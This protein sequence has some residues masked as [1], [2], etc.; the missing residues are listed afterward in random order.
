MAFFILT[1]TTVAVLGFTSV[2]LRQSVAMVL[3]L[4]S[5]SYLCI[6]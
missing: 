6:K 1:K 3:H 2:S 5:I 4:Y